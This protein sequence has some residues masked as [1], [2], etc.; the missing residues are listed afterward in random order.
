VLAWALYKNGR[1]ADA[2][3]AASRALRLGTEDAM[4]H[5]HAGMIAAALGHRRAATHHLERALALGPAF[6]VRQAPMARAEL[7]TL[8]GTQLVLV[9]EGDP[10]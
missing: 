9:H 8:R 2:K 5:Y 1:H 10:R 6:D 7:E 4:F 3:R